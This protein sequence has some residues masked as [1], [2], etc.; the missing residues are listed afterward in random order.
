MRLAANSVQVYPWEPGFSPES[1]CLLP[2]AYDSPHR[3]SPRAVACAGVR[4][5][6]DD[7]APWPA[8][9]HNHRGRFGGLG[10]APL[11]DGIDGLDADVELGREAR[12][13]GPD[14]LAHI[15]LALDDR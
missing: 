1:S 7:P 13:H 2:T 5:Q 9:I 15:L 8:A 3:S 6:A 4:V 10:P 11:A 14:V 12:R